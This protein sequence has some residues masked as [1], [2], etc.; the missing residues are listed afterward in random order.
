MS[1]CE[2]LV[3][4]VKDKVKSHIAVEILQKYKRKALEEIN[5]EYRRTIVSLPS[6]NQ[7]QNK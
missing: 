6:R 5:K 7:A 1:N 3:E 2:D 4:A